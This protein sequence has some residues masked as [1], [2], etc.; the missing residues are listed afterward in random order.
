M[1]ERIDRTAYG[2]YKPDAITDQHMRQFTE[3]PVEIV[4]RAVPNVEVRQ[5]IGKH[6]EQVFKDLKETGLL[7]LPRQLR[8]RPSPD[9]STKAPQT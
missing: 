8:E 4:K 1:L 2:R 7:H 9:A 5:V 3:I 6:V